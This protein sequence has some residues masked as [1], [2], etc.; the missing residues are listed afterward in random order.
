MAKTK[1]PT[2]TTTVEAFVAALKN[3]VT[4]RGSV[5]IPILGYARVQNA[6]V[7]GTT[8]DVF[9]IVKFEGKGQGDF[10]IHPRRAIDVLSGEK[11]PLV[12]EFHDTNE[13]RGERKVKLKVGTLEFTLPTLAVENFPHMPEP[14]K[15]TLAIDGAAL[16]TMID[17]TRIAVSADES[18]YTINGTLLSTE[19][20]TV[21]MVATDGHRMSVVTAPGEGE[22]ENVILSKSTTEWLRNNCRGK[23]QIGRDTSGNIISTD[24][25]IVISKTLSGQFPN[26]QAVI[27]TKSS[28]S[29]R[30]SSSKT[31]AAFLKRACKCASRESGTIK[32]FLEKGKQEVVIL[33]ESLERGSARVPVPAAIENMQTTGMTIGFCGEF[34]LDF[35]AVLPDQEF[36]LSLTKA[37]M[38][39]MFE[40]ENFKY[41]VMPMRL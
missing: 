30:F 16:K 10:L 38:A 17:R 23:V 34:I 28:V 27:P 3:T 5:T 4:E 40:V 13:P 41:I 15:T 31:A 18:R 9:T 36:T 19:N 26:Y 11:G 14:I 37:D 33:A 6:T 35:L 8:L 12:I 32:L 39:G 25:G 22:L 7:I 1:V 24:T 2:I 20:G 29:V 21:T